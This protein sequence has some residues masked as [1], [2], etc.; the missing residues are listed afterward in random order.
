MNESRIRRF[1]DQ[2]STDTIGSKL[3]VGQEYVTTED[4]QNYRH[5]RDGMLSGHGTHT[6]GIAAGTGFDT[7]YRGIAYESDICLVSNAVTSDTVLI[8][9]AQRWKYTTATD[10]LGF[11]Y[12]F[13]YAEQEGKPCVISFSEGSYEDLHGD[14]Q[15]FAAVLD[16]LV[17]PGRIVIASAGNEGFHNTFIRKPRG[18]EQTGAFVRRWGKDNAFLMK[19]DGPFS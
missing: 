11:K 15:L 5:S 4:I 19:S 14:N 6:L 17:G 10:A 16:S 7:P 2:L 3:Y 18:V 8:D 13:D 9:E 12:I 1:W